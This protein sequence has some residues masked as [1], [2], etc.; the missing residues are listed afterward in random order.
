V[1]FF[2]DISYMKILKVNKFS[3]DNNS[4]AVLNSER[5]TAILETAMLLPFLVVCCLSLFD[6]GRIFYSYL[7]VSEIA[8]EAALHGAKIPQ[9]EGNPV[10]DFF[11]HELNNATTPAN[12]GGHEIIRSRIRVARSLLAETIPVPI[13]SIS[14]QSQCVPEPSLDV[15]AGDGTGR[16]LRVRVTA[17]YQSLF[18]RGFPT[19]TIRAEEVVSYLGSDPC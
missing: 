11:D 15:N 17:G 7:M 8:R 1:S 6:V 4:D 3:A 10:G 5:G 12:L 18:L 16:A 14:S 9:L 13:T 19:L 2:C